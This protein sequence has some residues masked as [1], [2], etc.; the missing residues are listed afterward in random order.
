MKID[1]P[2]ASRRFASVTGLRPEKA[3][4]YEQLHAHPWPGIVRMI[5]QCH[6]HNYS[7]Y[8]REIDGRHFLFSYFEYDGDDLA[9]DMKTMAADPETQRWWRETDPCQIPLP[10]AAKA[11]KIWADAREVFHL[12]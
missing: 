7:I 10:D 11:G 4:Y 6:I 8:V 5:K 3:A 12:P 2:H 1:L 9:A